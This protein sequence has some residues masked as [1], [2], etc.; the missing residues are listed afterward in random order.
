MMEKKEIFINS[1]SKLSLNFF[2]H[3]KESKDEK[4]IKKKK[5]LLV[6]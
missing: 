5:T 2:F 1:K 4:I 3:C 6:K